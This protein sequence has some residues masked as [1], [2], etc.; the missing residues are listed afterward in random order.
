[1]PAR[2][3]DARRRWRRVRA[4]SLAYTAE[5]TLRTPATRFRPT[6]TEIESK[7][8]SLRSALQEGDVSGIKSAMH[9]SLHH[10]E[11]RRPCT[12]SLARSGEGRQARMTIREGEFREV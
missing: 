11:G 5:K 4:D 7:T 8:A 9:R 3:A 1:M 6:S 10:S 12:D 2:T